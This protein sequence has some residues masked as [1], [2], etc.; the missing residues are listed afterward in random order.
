[1]SEYQS[2]HD[3][4]RQHYAPRASFIDDLNQAARENPVSAALIGAGIL[5]MFVGSSRVLGGAGAAAGAVGRGTQQAAGAAASGVQ[6]AASGIG[7]AASAAASGVTQAASAVA[8]GI[9]SAAQAL[10]SAAGSIAGT[11]AGA[12][13][14][15][16]SGVTDAV[17]SAADWTSD[18]AGHAY[19]TGSDAAWHGSRS[20]AGGAADMS[21]GAQARLSEWGGEAKHTLAQSFERQPLLLGAVGVMLGA[22][23]AAALPV[24]DAENRMLGATSDS[25]KEMVTD[26]VAEKTDQAKDMAHTAMREAEAQGLTPQAASHAVQ[27]LVDKLGT[28][29]DKTGAAA[30]DR[31]SE[32]LLGTSNPR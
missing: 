22:A 7:S 26:L 10:G 28:V 32:V 4:E 15:A 13:R 23:A 29:A 1:M 2:W 8:G 3:R 11:A 9:G 20:V 25:I 27:D 31:V 30:K 18:T 5:M 17:S 12:A 19:Q 24:T 21:R 6:Q 16:A 14:S